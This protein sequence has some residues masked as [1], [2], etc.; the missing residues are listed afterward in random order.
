[1]LKDTT[2]LPITAK[3]QDAVN[4]FEKTVISYFRFGIDIGTNLKETYSKDENM[5]FAHILR[6]YFMHLMGSRK[7]LTKAEDALSDAKKLEREI[8][9][10]ELLHLKSLEYWCKLDLKKTTA[11]WQEIADQYPGDALAIKM[12]HYTYF[13]LGD[14]KN[15]K[16]SIDKSWKYWTQKKNSPYYS[17]LL[18][19][20]AFG[21]EENGYYQEAKELAYEAYSINKDDAWAVH[22]ISHVYEMNDQSSDGVKWIRES[23]LPNKWNNFR[24]HLQWHKA[25]MSLNICTNDEILK[26]YDTEIFD[27]NSQEYL[28]LI[29]NISLLLRLEMLNIDVGNRWDY[30]YEKINTRLNDHILAFIDIHFMICLCYKD[31]NLAKNYLENIKK[32]QDESKDTYAEISKSITLLLCK[33]IIFYKTQKFDKCIQIL[34]EAEGK[35]Y[36]IGGS[37]AQRDILNLIHLDSLLRIKNQDKLQNFIKKRNITRPNNKFYEKLNHSIN[38]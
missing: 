3:N 37:N 18:S 38:N 15:L 25:I 31:I 36:L 35:S 21:L 8:T 9:Q 17:Y 13:Y 19:L 22:T 12:L 2:G 11:C 23:F 24:Y 27:E 6:G 7:M 5:F 29:N 30:I 32:Y 10:R 33:A 26:I 20:K 14:Q 16:F 28:D 4:A 1:M 34:E